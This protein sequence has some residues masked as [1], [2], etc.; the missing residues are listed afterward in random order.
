MFKYK[1]AGI[2]IIN[3]QIEKEDLHMSRVTRITRA[4]W[5]RYILSEQEKKKEN[6]NVVMNTKIEHTTQRSQHN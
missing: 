1:Y 6:K 4:P 2:R 3:M 5:Q